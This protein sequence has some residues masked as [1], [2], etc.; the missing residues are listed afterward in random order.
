[1][2]NFLTTVGT[3]QK[4]QVSDFQIRDAQLLKPVQ[5]LQNLK[6]SQTCCIWDTE[7]IHF[8][9]HFTVFEHHEGQKSLTQ[10]D[11]GFFNSE[12]RLKSGKGCWQSLREFGT[13]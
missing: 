2:L 10:Y 4:F 7:H 5:V 9:Y 1:M 3:L 8:S 11:G 6:P 12:V 13:L